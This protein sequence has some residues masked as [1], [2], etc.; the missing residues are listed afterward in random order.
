MKKLIGT[1]L[2]LV[3]LLFVIG[4]SVNFAQAQTDIQRDVTG[5]TQNAAKKPL[6][7]TQQ[8]LQEGLNETPESRQISAGVFGGVTIACFEYGQCTFCDILIVLIT[9]SDII[10]RLF[11]ILA[12]IFFIWGAG[13]LMLS[14]GNETLVKKGKD[15][16]KATV[17]G[18]VI[19]LV[20]WQLMSF[21]VI[22][23]ANGNIFDEGDKITKNPVAGWYKVAQSCSKNN[24]EANK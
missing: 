16:I 14:S 4:P 7:K 8:A 12:L 20:A 18:S 21:I 24:T 11:A 13:Y 1:Q 23:L 22:F 10:L 3:C 17:I 19:V 9:I 6:S 15:I 2:L 5:G